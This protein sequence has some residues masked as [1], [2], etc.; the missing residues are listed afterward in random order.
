MMQ[1]SGEGHFTRHSGRAAGKHERSSMDD[2]T[3]YGVSEIELL[4]TS[5]YSFE[6]FLRFT[7]KSWNA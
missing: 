2:S 3:Q 1:A 6:L 4:I 7:M 5:Q